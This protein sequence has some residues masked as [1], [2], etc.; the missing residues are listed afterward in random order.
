MGTEDWQERFEA[1]L[2][3]AQAARDAGNE[4]RAR[5]CARRAAGIIIARYLEAREIPH[6]NTSAYDLLKYF[7]GYSGVPDSVREITGH[8]LVRIDTDYKLPIDADLIQ[9]A[10][11]LADTLV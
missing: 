7:A 2:A 5:V 10:R 4:G 6:P 11:W 1:E 9:D 3:Q 8:F